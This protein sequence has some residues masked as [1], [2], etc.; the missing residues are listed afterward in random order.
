MRNN[1]LYSSSNKKKDKSLDPTQIQ[2]TL[3]E[4]LPEQLKLSSFQKEIEEDNEFNESKSIQKKLNRNLPENLKISN[5]SETEKLNQ[6][7]SQKQAESSEKDKYEYFDEEHPS[8]LYERNFKKE[9][10][11]HKL[12]RS[13]KEE[14]VE[15]SD[16]NYKINDYGKKIEDQSLTEKSFENS[17]K[18]K[19]RVFRNLDEELSKSLI[20]PSLYESNLHEYIKSQEDYLEELENDRKNLRNK[21]FSKEESFI[22]QEKKDSNENFRNSGANYEVDDDINYYSKSEM[23]KKANSLVDKFLGVEKKFKDSDESRLS[24]GLLKKMILKVSIV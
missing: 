2:K 22:K 19:Q 5:L 24:K 11:K 21:I 10:F 4:N 12:E 13:L 8:D 9:A 3:N 15:K 16:I 7:L 6:Y 18:L 14:E 1:E 17:S 20:N 23:N